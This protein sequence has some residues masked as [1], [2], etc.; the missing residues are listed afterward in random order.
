MGYGTWLT[1]TLTDRLAHFYEGLRW[2][3]WQQETVNL[4]AAEGIT[5]YP[6]LWSQEAQ[7]NLATTTRAPAPMTELHTMNQDLCQQMGLPA[8]GFLG[9]V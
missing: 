1:W 2:P 4:T 8:P 5:V 3:G 6:F 9:A 7:D